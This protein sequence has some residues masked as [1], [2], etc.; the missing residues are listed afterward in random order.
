MRTRGGRPTLIAENGVVV[1]SSGQRPEG[2]PEV[3]LVAERS[4]AGE[5]RR[6]SPYT[7]RGID[8]V[9]A[10]EGAT[11]A[12]RD[13]GAVARTN[14]RIAAA[15]IDTHV[16]A[17]VD[18]EAFP[19]GRIVGVVRVRLA[20]S[21]TQASGALAP[22][23]II[24]RT[25]AKQHLELHGVLFVDTGQVQPGFSELRVQDIHVTAGWGLR[26]YWN[27]DFVLRSDFGISNEQIYTTVKLS[28]L[29]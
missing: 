8:P 17:L 28:N 22:G 11:G 21:G 1:F 3:V 19:P 15:K 24:T 16:G 9:V 7:D 25:V 4:A 26:T 23:T 27:A 13:D 5:A 2:A 20:E 29:F 18:R 10:Y 12:T 14:D 6:A